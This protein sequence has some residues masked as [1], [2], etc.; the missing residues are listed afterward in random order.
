M[1]ARTAWDSLFVVKGRPDRP[2]EQLDFMFD[3]AGRGL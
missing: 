1:A 2:R 3:P